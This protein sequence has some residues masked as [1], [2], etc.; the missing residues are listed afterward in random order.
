M[1]AKGD[2]LEASLM[3]GLKH[4]NIVET[5]EHKTQQV[6]VRPASLDQEYG[7]HF[8]L[9]QSTPDRKMPKRP[10]LASLSQS[11]KVMTYGSR[12]QHKMLACK[13]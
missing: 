10:A 7:A 9:T 12:S 13:L 1:D 8:I 11:D 6:Q 2:P 5:I 3:L 4:P